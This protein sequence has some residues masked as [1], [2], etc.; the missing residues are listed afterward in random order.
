MVQPSHLHMTTGK[1]VALA[2]QIFV[3]KVMSLLFNTHS[4]RRICTPTFDWQQGGETRRKWVNDAAIMGSKMSERPDTCH[5]HE[6]LRRREGACFYLWSHMTKW[7]GKLV[8]FCLITFECL[9]CARHWLWWVSRAWEGKIQVLSLRRFVWTTCDGVEVMLWVI[10][11]RTWGW[12]LVRALSRGDL[13]FWEV[14]WHA[15][16]STF[17]IWNVFKNR[18]SWKCGFLPNADIKGF[19]KTCLKIWH[20]LGI[21]RPVPK[22]LF[23]VDF[24]IKPFCIDV[25]HYFI[26][27]FWE[28]SYNCKGEKLLTAFSS[29]HNNCW[30]MAPGNI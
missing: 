30:R 21:N 10:K 2:R 1:A 12:T 11:V 6:K 15:V 20:L 28:M 3:G 7:K 26:S 22:T 24:S 14:P 8:W 13:L 4:F 17:C 5:L 19:K 27:R 9:W 23:I 18:Y 16:S 29:H 25:Y